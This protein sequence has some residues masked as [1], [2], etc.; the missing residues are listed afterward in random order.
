MGPS[1][2]AVKKVKRTTSRTQ[3]YRRMVRA[4]Y[5]APAPPLTSAQSPPAPS[6]CEPAAGKWSPA[7]RW[8]TRCSAW[9]RRGSGCRSPGGQEIGENIS[10]TT[11]FN[12]LT[13]SSSGS[14]RPG[15]LNHV[16]RRAERANTTRDTTIA[17]VLEKVFVQI[18]EHQRENHLFIYELQLLTGVGVH[19]YGDIARPPRLVL[20]QD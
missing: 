13:L 18:T 12:P 16:P 20:H 11:P 9:C 15:A 17:A 2:T 3:T 10:I 14:H 5:S 4:P 8:S 19:V 1:P 6:P 7:P